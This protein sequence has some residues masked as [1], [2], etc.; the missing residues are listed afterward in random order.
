MGVYWLRKDSPAIGKGSKEYA[1]PTD[2]WGRLT[3]RTSRPT[4]GRLPINLF[5]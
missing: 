1:L 5:A 3:P 2:F 4:S